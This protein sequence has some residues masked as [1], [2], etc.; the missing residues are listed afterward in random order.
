MT[1]AQAS[2]AAIPALAP[3]DVDPLIRAA[4]EEDLRAGDRASEVAAA[5]SIS[6]RVP[7]RDTRKTAPGLRRLEKDA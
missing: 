4:L 1:P 5:P 7:I 2:V 3:E 6:V